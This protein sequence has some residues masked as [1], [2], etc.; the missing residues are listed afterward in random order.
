MN[1]M[2][3]AQ[4][5]AVLAGAL[6]MFA[7]GLS[8][9]ALSY[10]VAP[11]SEGIGCSRAAFNL[12]YTIMSIVGF[13]AAPFF[14]HLLDRIPIQRLLLTGAV[15]GGGCLAAFSFCRVIPAFYGIAVVLGLI[16]NGC[17]QMSAVV[18]INRS[19]TSGSGSAIGL[20]MAG[21]GV[22]SVILSLVL[23]NF[24][25]R[26]GWEN[27]YRLQGI[28]WFAVMLFACM[29]AREG[30]NGAKEEAKEGGVSE[31]DLEGV[32]YK[33]AVKSPSLYLLM[34]CVTVINMTSLFLQ[35]MPAY[36]VELGA[37]PVIAGTIMSVFSIFLIVC[38]IS[39]GSLFDKLGPIRT[40]CVAFTSFAL[41]MWV[42][43]LGDIRLLYVAAA[44]AA[45][46]MSS[47]TVLVPLVTK[48]IFGRK[49][50]APIWGMIT[51]AT[52]IGGAVG[53]PAW[54]L[55]YDLLGSYRPAVLLA[56]VLV[57]ADLCVLVV[58]MKKKL[59]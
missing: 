28:S 7:Y 8:N 40:T 20:A 17:T 32:S 46:G 30:H 37:T 27:A 19:F 16:Q 48:H 52:A 5:R 57:F 49:E 50:Y 6:L 26:F 12:Y 36:F 33:E 45:F 34:L 38:K 11:V 22:C 15:I 51:M 24:I 1:I 39:L 4:K 59:W 13:L 43:S 42:M 25:E 54:G 47:T 2:T 53:S 10:M 14:G 58:L 35:H 44:M 31:E 29:L 9:N 56:P 21:T 18:L 23:P 41:S 3:K 55:V